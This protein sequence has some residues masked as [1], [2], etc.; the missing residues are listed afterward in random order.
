MLIYTQ[1]AG[2][3]LNQFCIWTNKD[4]ACVDVRGKRGFKSSVVNSR[5]K[6]KKKSIMR[7][8]KSTHMI[9][10]AESCWRRNIN[11]PWKLCKCVA[12]LKQD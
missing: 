6:E 7:A 9:S 12:L 5:E 1:I 11:K 2:V 4:V 8:Y 3:C 10:L